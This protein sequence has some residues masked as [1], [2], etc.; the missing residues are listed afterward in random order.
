[1]TTPAEPLMSLNASIAR[2]LKLVYLCNEDPNLQALELAKSKKSLLHWISNWAWTFDTRETANPFVPFDIFPRQ[3]EFLLW[4][5]EREVKKQDGLCEKS[6]D[7]GISWLC[8]AYALHGWLFRR[9]YSVGFGSRKLEYVDEKGNPK[10][11][12]EKL[13]LLL[14]RLPWWMRPPG[15]NDKHHSAEGKLINPHNGSTI[16]GEGG[17]NIGRG[18]RTAIFF[19][20]EA[21]FIERADLID[22]SLSQTTN[23]RIDVSTPNGIG[24]SFWRKRF[25][26]PDEQI[27]IFDWRDDPR[28]D[29]AWYE[30]QKGRFDEIT[31]A[32]EIDRDYSASVQ[33][34]TIPAAWVQAAIGL[35]LPAKGECVAG[36]DVAAGGKN[37]SVYISRQG[38]VVKR[39][40]DWS[41]D[42]TQ[43]A[44]RAKEEAITDGATVLNYDAAGVGC[45]DGATLV[46][47]VP[48]AER[49][50]VGE[51][52]T[53]GGSALSSPGFC[54][55]KADLYRVRTRS[56]RSVTVTAAHRFLTPTGWLSLSRLAV[57]SP[58]AADDSES[59]RSG[60]EKPTSW[61]DHCSEDHCPCDGQHKCSEWHVANRAWQSAVPADV[62]L[63]CCVF[64]IGRLSIAS[65]LPLWHLRH[66]FYGQSAPLRGGYGSSQHIHQTAARSMLLILP[67]YRGGESLPLAVWFDALS[68]TSF[69]PH[70]FR[71]IEGS[72]IRERS[73]CSEDEQLRFVCR[74]QT[75]GGRQRGYRPFGLDGIGTR[76]L[77]EL[78]LRQCRRRWDDIQ[79]ISWVRKGEFYD[80]HV[81]FW[82]HY[83]A[84]GLWHHNS[85]VRTGLEMSGQLPFLPRAVMT[86]G[87]PSERTWEDGRTSKERFLNLRAEAT[88]LL[89][90]RFRK[91]FEFK[92]QGVAHPPEDCISIPF[93]PQLIAELSQPL[94]F[95][96]GTKLKIEA[97]EDMVKR[98]IKSPD[99]ADA[100]VLCFMDT[101]AWDSIA[102][103]EGKPSIMS[104]LPKEIA[105]PREEIWGVEG[106]DDDSGGGINW[107]KWMEM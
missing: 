33:G 62:V 102:A 5:R 66:P 52:Q 106:E 27:F 101:S 13:R 91:A 47:G 56:G 19:C 55:G 22:R 24:N 6:R 15:F 67:R 31:V 32:Q 48:I 41:Q 85:G 71:H 17:D 11:I 89:R 61:Q 69:V 87:A 105:L 74:S 30:A 9:G 84:A 58:I 2:R 50:Q 98:G 29:Q 59:A 16:T 4:L 103:P 80:L 57:G 76:L 53:L 82:H 81:P 70:G 18:D 46:G 14:E 40:V 28:K 86:G 36:L 68:G 26:L 92:T 97:K 23:V 93:H 90:D 60:W 104:R 96:Q 94:H 34:V 83:S 77:Q 54:K 88:W 3:C 20:D 10:T 35:D 65:F 37:K 64:L 1:M 7:V 79:D 12:F 49:R 100:L 25:R 21:A 73:L 63:G 107:S 78:P 43:G 75:R 72:A 99:F 45:L 95:V 39:I 51:V 8:C 44:W 42:T 38:P